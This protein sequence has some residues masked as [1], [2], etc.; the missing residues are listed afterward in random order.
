MATI[1]PKTVTVY[2]S[3]EVEIRFEWSRWY[4]FKCWLRRLCWWR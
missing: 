3:P 2:F 1:R 4:L